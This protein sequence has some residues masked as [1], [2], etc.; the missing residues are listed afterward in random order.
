MLGISVFH[1]I[2]DAIRAWRRA[3]QPQPGCSRDPERVLLAIE[4]LKRRA[5]ATEAVGAQAAE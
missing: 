5:A 2:N 4:D 1:A 3:P